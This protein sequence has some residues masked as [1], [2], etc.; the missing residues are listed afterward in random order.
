MSDYLDC[1]ACGGPGLPPSSHC[2]RRGPRWEE[3]DEGACV[4]C[5]V[6]LVVREGGEFDDGELWMKAVEVNGE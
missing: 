1:P 4:T 5:G 3:D 2:I 6:P